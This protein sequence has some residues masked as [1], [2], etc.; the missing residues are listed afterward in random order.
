MILEL[1]F[2]EMANLLNRRFPFL[3]T[4]G[5]SPRSRIKWTAR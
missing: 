4:I 2:Y 5:S 3:S 1:Y